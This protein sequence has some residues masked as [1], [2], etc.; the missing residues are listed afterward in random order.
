MKVAVFT[1]WNS[2]RNYGQVLQAYALLQLLR[3]RGL[4]AFLVNYVRVGGEIRVSKILLR[5]CKELL[6]C[7]LKGDALS[8]WRFWKFRRKQLRTS[9]KTYYAFSELARTPPDADIYVCGSDQV[10]NWNF[11]TPPDAFLLNF[12]SDAVKRYSYAASFGQSHID[13]S[14][15]Q[16]YENAFQRFDGVSVR[17]RDGVELCKSV[18]YPNAVWVPDPTLMLAAER[19]TQLLGIERN[20]KSHV[21]VYTLG[22]SPIDSREEYIRFVKSRGKVLHVS[23]NGDSSG[24]VKPGVEKWVELL[25]NASF[26]LTNSFHGMV[27]SIVFRVNFVVIPNTGGARGMNGRIESLCERLSLRNR[28]MEAFDEKKLVGLFHESIDWISVDKKLAD[29]RKDGETFLNKI[30]E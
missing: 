15:S 9:G 2:G 4:D 5:R 16:K 20:K 27:F 14:L 28:I 21:F 19:W 10:W 29:W 30:G 22:N 11:Q 17:E 13:Q 26:V 6:R 8:E 23:A 1:F 18:G 12:G 3:D 25:S 24:N 7:V